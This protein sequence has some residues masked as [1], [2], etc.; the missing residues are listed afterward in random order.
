MPTFRTVQDWASHRENSHLERLVSPQLQLEARMSERMVLEPVDCPLC[1]YSPYKVSPE[2]DDHIANHMQTFALNALP[3]NSS[4]T[5]QSE[6]VGFYPGSTASK[7]GSTNSTGTKMVEEQI[8]K[9]SY[10]ANKYLTGIIDSWHVNHRHPEWSHDGIIETL[11]QRRAID[12]IH[13]LLPVVYTGLSGSEDPLQLPRT[14]EQ[15]RSD[16]RRVLGD[17]GKYAQSNSQVSLAEALEKLISAMGLSRETRHLS[18]IVLSPGNWV[19]MSSITEIAS[20]LYTSHVRGRKVNLP[21]EKDVK[22]LFGFFGDSEA[23]ARFLSGLDLLPPLRSRELRQD[24]ENLG[25]SDANDI[26]SVKELSSDASPTVLLRYLAESSRRPNSR[27]HTEDRD[28]IR[29]AANDISVHG[30]PNT[31]TGSMGSRHQTGRS[32]KSDII[33][34]HR[35]ID[36]GTASLSPTSEEEKLVS[37]RIPSYHL[38]LDSLKEYLRA[39]FPRQS[40]FSIQSRRGS[41]H[42]TVPRYLTKDEMERIVD[43]SRRR[44]EGVSL[45]TKSTVEQHKSPEKDRQRVPDYV[46]SEELPSTKTSILDQWKYIGNPTMFRR[47]EGSMFLFKEKAK[48]GIF[49]T[50]PIDMDAISA[51]EA[52]SQSNS[53][54]DTESLNSE[55]TY[56]KTVAGDIEGEDSEIRKLGHGVFVALKQP[57]SSKDNEIWDSI[58]PRLLDVIL[59]SPGPD[60]RRLPSVALEFVMTGRYKASLKP[61]VIISH[62]EAIDKKQLRR[63]LKSQE[64]LAETGYPVLIVAHSTNYIERIPAL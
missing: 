39:L 17:K 43:S 59:N 10:T 22:A 2:D 64:W 12:D 7:P 28:N 21:S 32:K 1:L 46:S 48:D 8:V 49:G 25:I 29:V 19:N 61:S 58:R 41:Y 27:K 23:A 52:T 63:T 33:A 55:T 45:N 57:I 37:Q 53:P 31:S 47:S 26:I 60:P 35:W 16:F 56:M 6:D 3:W 42:I 34:L 51:H 30:T 4:N 24:L 40:E 9:P 15:M 20:V 36:G 54:T 38:R 14:S 62:L 13:Q 18:I 5:F 50:S 44:D 11:G